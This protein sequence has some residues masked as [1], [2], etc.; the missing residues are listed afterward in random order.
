MR[1]SITLRS[2]AYVAALGFLASVAQ[3]VPI[4]SQGYY[5]E[6]LSRNCF[7]ASSCS[8]PFSAVPA[9]KTLIVTNVSCQLLTSG[10]NTAVH[11]A[12]LTKVGGGGPTFLETSVF[13]TA[14][15]FRRF[16]SNTQ[17]TKIYRAGESPSVSV[18]FTTTISTISMNCHISGILKP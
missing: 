4:I 5:E 3:A 7:N 2:A 8:V 6:F 18:S 10:T 9:G 16:L 13:V 11:A 14:T 17:V 12:S 1:I 15:T